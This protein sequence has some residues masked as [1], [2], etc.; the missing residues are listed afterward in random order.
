MTYNI[1]RLSS[2]TQRECQ[3]IYQSVDGPLV[4]EEFAMLVVYVSGPIKYSLAPGGLGKYDKPFG[5]DIPRNKGLMRELK[6][7]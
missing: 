6:D 5:D 1:E 4:L 2:K 3:I 7:F